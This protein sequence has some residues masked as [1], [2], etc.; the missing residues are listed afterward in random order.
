MP[1]DPRWV[2]FV[3]GPVVLAAR[4]SQDDLDGLVAGD[5]RMGHVA[6]GPL[7]PLVGTPVVVGD[8]LSRARE[9]TDGRVVLDVHERGGAGRLVL[10]PFAFLHDAR[11]SLYLP[12]VPGDGDVE[13]LLAELATLDAAAARSERTLDAVAAGQQQPEVDHGFRGGA[14]TPGFEDGRWWRTTTDWFSYEL[15]TGGAPRPRLVVTYL[16]G[17]A[18]TEVTADGVVVLTL[19]GGAPGAG[20]VE[21]DVV[22]ELTR[23]TVTV[24]L[25]VPGEGPSVRV[26][27]CRLERHLT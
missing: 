13:A 26:V 4:T 8:P 23:D 27:G 14:S 5:A 18:P 6:A 20:P 22:L 7:R 12:S 16:P 15:T 21:A 25:Q 17:G 11:Y 19:D 9:D 10:E 24:G 3:R 1:G 2:S